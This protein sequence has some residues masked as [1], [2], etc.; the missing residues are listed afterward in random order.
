MLKG[1]FVHRRQVT[2]TLDS[3]GRI[4]Q[5]EVEDQIE[6]SDRESHKAETLLHLHPATALEP[7]CT[8]AANGAPA[9]NSLPLRQPDDTIVLLSGSQPINTNLRKSWYC[10]QFGSHEKNTVISLAAKSQSPI[11]ISYRL[12]FVQQKQ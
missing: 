1:H 6:G 11:S 5:L 12:D 8:E 4:A 9:I 7:I 2:L 3:D 10:E